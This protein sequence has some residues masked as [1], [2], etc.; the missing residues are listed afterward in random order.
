MACAVYMILVS[1]SADH[2]RLEV[3]FVELGRNGHT[4]LLVVDRITHNELFQNPVFDEDA[5][6]AAIEH[7][8]F[9]VAS[10]GEA[11]RGDAVRRCEDGREHDLLP[12]ALEEAEEGRL[13]VV[14]IEPAEELGVGED[15]SPPLADGGGA[16][17]RV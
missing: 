5:A 15:A 1:G 7:L 4:V 10:K 9:T 2:C 3:G 8:V 16:G 11:P 17:E 14:C 13:A 12:A 6:V